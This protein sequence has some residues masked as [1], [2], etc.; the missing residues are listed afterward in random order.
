MV[1]YK[2]IAVDEEGRVVSRL[3]RRNSSK[4]IIEHYKA[5]LKKVHPEFEFRIIQQ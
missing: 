1:R 5:R 2:I 3:T 4:Q